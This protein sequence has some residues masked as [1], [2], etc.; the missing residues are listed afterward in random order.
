MDSVTQLGDWKKISVLGSGAFGIVVLFKNVTTSDFVGKCQKN[1][2]ILKK[3]HLFRLFTAI[4][5]CK[6]SL[7]SSLTEKQKQRWQNEVLIM[8][9]LH[10]ENIIKFKAIPHDLEASIS[11]FNTTKLP[12]LSM[13]YCSKGNLRHVLHDTRNLS[14]L[15]ETDVRFLLS[16]IRNGLEYL[17]SKKVTHRDLKPDNI[18]LQ[19][20]GA[21]KTDTIY[22]IIDLGYAKELNGDKVSFVGTLDYLAPEIF[23]T[24]NYTS[25]VDY[26]SF[27]VLTFEV[28]CG[29]LPFLA[30]TATP[31]ER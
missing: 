6:F 9:S 4:K 23:Q 24:Q 21:R 1:S 11:K 30:G 3:I 18:V 8:K 5:L 13:E 27:G 15:S 26:W 17:H 29:V 19:S 20:F 12:L 10:H 2:K 16:D 7:S 25:A 31:F 14:G 22:K 28:I